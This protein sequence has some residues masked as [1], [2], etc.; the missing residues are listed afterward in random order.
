MD[1]WVVAIATVEGLGANPNGVD[2]VRLEAVDVSHRVRPYLHALPLVHLGY[3]EHVVVD[4]VARDAGKIGWRV[5]RHFNGRGCDALHFDVRWSWGHW[6]DRRNGGAGLVNVYTRK[7]TMTKGKSHQR[8]TFVYLKKRWNTNKTERT[9]QCDGSTIGL[10]WG[11]SFNYALA[12][13]T[14]GFK[15]YIKIKLNCGSLWTFKN[16]Y[17]V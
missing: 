3:G 16:L 1:F 7:S 10:F 12:A 17:L 11:L 5:P 6:N 4:A 2:G 9:I 13:S 15:S 14:L 8:K